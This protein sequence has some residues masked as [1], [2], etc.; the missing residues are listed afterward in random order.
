MAMRGLRAKAERAND[1]A[2]TRA[3]L[4]ADAPALRTVSPA[5]SIDASTVFEGSLRCQQML[6]IDGRLEG[7]VECEKS[8]LVGEGARVQASI[9]ADEIQVAGCVEG[10]MTARRKI[11]LMRTAVVTGD[12]A[13]PGIVVEEGARLQGRIVIGTDAEADRPAGPKQAAEP[14]KSSVSASAGSNPDETLRPATRT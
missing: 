14:A 12:L 9:T 13:T 11:T 10:D 3:P 7:H 5:T 2:E 4:P 1:A 6:R 8:V